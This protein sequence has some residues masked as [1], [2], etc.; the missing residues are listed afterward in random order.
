M[1]KD[2]EPISYQEYKEHKE[3]A[4]NNYKSKE[5]SE[6]DFR[7][8]LARLGLNA[9]EIDEEVEAIKNELE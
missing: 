4:T 9:T 8:A 1:T 5:S 2:R 3:A 6:E 7:K